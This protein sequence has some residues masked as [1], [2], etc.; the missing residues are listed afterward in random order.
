VYVGDEHRDVEACREVGVKVIAVRWGFDAEARL[1]AA[2][3]D[4]LATAP[5]E[6]SECVKRWSGARG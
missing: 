3:P 2:G 1:L 4:H 5:G 6:V